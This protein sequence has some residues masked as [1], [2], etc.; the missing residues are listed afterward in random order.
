MI[1]KLSARSVETAKSAGML[2][3]GGGLYLQVTANRRTGTIRKSWVYRFRICGR[4]REM[5]LG[6][7]PAVT[8]AKAREAAQVARAMRAARVDPIDNRREGEAARQLAAGR[9]KSN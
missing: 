8:L 4:T 2:S 1:G 3:D 5:G 7:V 9:S 6:P